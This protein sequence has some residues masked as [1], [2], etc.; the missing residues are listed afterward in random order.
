[1]NRYSQVVANYCWYKSMSFRKMDKGKVLPQI[2]NDEHSIHKPNESSL[3]EN[4][5]KDMFQ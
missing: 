1:M 3:L 2:Q 5:M 4:E